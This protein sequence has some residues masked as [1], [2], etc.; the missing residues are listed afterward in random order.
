M[1]G[2]TKLGLAAAVFAVSALTL[3]LYSLNRDETHRLRRLV[4]DAFLLDHHC[5]LVADPNRRLTMSSTVI[6]Q[7]TDGIYEDNHD[8]E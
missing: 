8:D 3:L 7:C 4:H 5:T 2:E 6:Y 1:K